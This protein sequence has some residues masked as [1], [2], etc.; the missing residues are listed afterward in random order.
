MLFA[1]SL[2]QLLHDG[3]LEPPRLR[4]SP[5]LARFSRTT[6]S[7]SASPFDGDP[8]RSPPGP[9]PQSAPPSAIFSTRRLSPLL[10]TRGPLLSTAVSSRWM[11]LSALCVLH[12]VVIAA[13]WFTFF[14]PTGPSSGMHFDSASP[15]SSPME[16]VHYSTPVPIRPLARRKAAADASST[17]G[18][19]TLGKE[20]NASVI[21]EPL[22]AVVVPAPALRVAAPL[23]SEASLLSFT[24]DLQRS[25]CSPTPTTPPPALLVYSCHKNAAALEHSDELFVDRHLGGVY[26]MTRSMLMAV[27]TQRA[28]V[29]DQSQCEAVRKI[30]DWVGRSSGV[31]CCD[32]EETMQPLVP[33]AVDAA[34]VQSAATDVSPFSVEE[35]AVT[36]DARQQC[37]WTDDLWSRVAVMFPDLSQHS[38]MHTLTSFLLRPSAAFSRHLTALGSALPPPSSPALVLHVAPYNPYLDNTGQLTFSRSPALNAYIAYIRHHAA[39]TPLSPSTLLLWANAEQTAIVRAELPHLQVVSVEAVATEYWK[40]QAEVRPLTALLSLVLLMAQRAD[41]WVGL[42]ASAATQLV[43]LR[44]EKPLRV[45]DVNGDWW[46][47]SCWSTT[48]HLLS[49]H[50]SAPHAYN[51]PSMAHLLSSSSNHS[52]PLV[53][54]A[55]LIH[56]MGTIRTGVP[57]LN[58]F[59]STYANVTD[60]PVLSL[61]WTALFTPR[62]SMRQYGERHQQFLSYL[63]TMLAGPGGSSPRRILLRYLMPSQESI[64]LSLSNYYHASFLAQLVNEFALPASVHVVVLTREPEQALRQE[65]WNDAVVRAV[66][67][68]QTAALSQGKAMRDV[69]SSFEAELLAMDVSAYRIF[70]YDQLWSEERLPS[71]AARMAAFL[72]MDDG[73]AAS[74]TEQ[75]AAFFQVVKA[76]LYVSASKVERSEDNSAVNDLLALAPALQLNN[77]QHPG[78]QHHTFDYW[79]AM[80]SAIELAPD[81]PP[82]VTFMDRLQAHQQVDDCRK[83]HA[84]VFN[85]FLRWT[86]AT[87]LSAQVLDVLKAL[88]LALA[89]GRVLVLPRVAG[90]VLDWLQPVTACQAGEFGKFFVERVDD[91]WTVSAWERGLHS[92]ALSAHRIVVTHSQVIDTSYLAVWNVQQP[93]QRLSV[94]EYVSAM[95]AFILRPT[96][97]FDSAHA[98]AITTKPV[99]LTVIL[100]LAHNRPLAWYVHAVDSVIAALGVRSVSVT[101]TDGVF[102]H[103]TSP[104]FMSLLGNATGPELALSV[105]TQLRSRWSNVT[106]ALQQPE[107]DGPQGDLVLLQQARQ[108]RLLLGSLSSELGFLAASLVPYSDW[109]D[110]FGAQ[111]IPAL[112]ALNHRSLLHTQSPSASHVRPAVD[113]T[114]VAPVVEK[115]R[116][117][118][119]V[120]FVFVAGL[121]GTGHHGIGHLL[122]GMRVYTDVGVY[123]AQLQVDEWLNNFGWKMV[124]ETNSVAYDRYKKQLVQRIKWRSDQHR[125]EMDAPPIFVINTIQDT[126][127]GMQSWP[128]TDL[129]E[130]ATLHPSLVVMARLFQDVNA[131]FRVIALQRTPGSALASAKR[132][133]HGISL[134]GAD[135][136]FHYLAR[137]ARSNLASLDADLRALDPAFTLTLATESI[138]T[139]PALVARAIARHL[140]FADGDLVQ[141]ALRMKEEVVVHPSSYWM[142]SMNPTEIQLTQDVLGLSSLLP[143]SDQFAFSTGLVGGQ[144]DRRVRPGVEATGWCRT[145]RVGVRHQAKGFTV[146]TMEGAGADYLR[147]LI[148]ESSAVMTSKYSRDRVLPSSTSRHVV[149]FAEANLTAFTL[150]EYPVT[151]VTA[152]Q[153]WSFSLPVAKPLPTDPSSVRPTLILTRNPLDL[154]L[155]VAFERLQSAPELADERVWDFSRDHF[156]RWRREHLGAL[157]TTVRS[158][159]ASVAEAYNRWASAWDVAKRRQEMLEAGVSKDGVT[160]LRMEDLLTTPRHSLVQLLELFELSADASALGCVQ[161]AAESVGFNTRLLSGTPPTSAPTAR[162]MSGHPI[163]NESV[164]SVQFALFSA[165]IP[166]YATAARPF[167]LAHLIPPEVFAEFVKAV[168][169]TALAI[170]GEDWTKYTE[171]VTLRLAHYWGSQTNNAQAQAPPTHTPP[172]PRSTVH[173]NKPTNAPSPSQLLDRT[174]PRQRVT[175]SAAARDIIDEAR[176]LETDLR[177]MQKPGSYDSSPAANKAR[178]RLNVLRKLIS[179]AQQGG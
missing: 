157:V 158:V 97:E 2:Q 68:E 63:R 76:D 17:A 109:Y 28:L 49:T 86:D 8:S 71:E 123:Y 74:F 45:W 105:T 107:F 163:Y 82:S 18:N 32:W 56:L 58:R 39:T 35:S 38:V 140:G 29:L 119:S 95:L 25:L 87:R 156:A 161:S 171:E 139:Q 16:R 14:S 55:Q 96:A 33:C 15:L 147:V 34:R 137:V 88:S 126:V 134:V 136:A 110:L 19:G 169:A 162:T 102:Q 135:N 52:S 81:V 103:V 36:Y 26:A 64:D 101:W 166:T 46:T 117:S 50:H 89:S 168:D 69:L 174:T 143:M 3:N 47:S 77:L 73:E 79:R 100:P 104:S 30:D 80:A 37:L 92:D 116:W 67:S 20:Q 61:H 150:L 159:L 53:H 21:A 85:G 1:S 78:Y 130:K 11:L 176:K 99:D 66:K 118:R 132:R 7:L 131:D 173:P 65:V 44:A 165:S 149:A 127:G 170:E 48:A 98:Q 106:I 113:P 62:Q 151:P 75:L 24:V 152:A 23:P 128:N 141:A 146:V 93:A 155:A 90:T 148:E 13:V 22:D 51:N 167:G 42:H 160:V 154:A 144:D 111:Y 122:Q 142:S 5:N 121:E 138:E 12:V 129:A 133:D 125:S 54:S 60:D 31:A 94:H 178:A 115:T 108:S 179:Q 124:K 164:A 43:Q 112:L 70:R 145:R 172:P 27:A 83:A 6:S 114:A 40:S 57:E 91:G 41:E 153:Q 120:R 72:R 177:L 59:L 10:S 9:F 84:L 175:S 4:H